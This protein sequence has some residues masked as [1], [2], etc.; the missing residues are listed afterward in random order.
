MDTA[1]TAGIV[2]VF[3]RAGLHRDLRERAEQDAAEVG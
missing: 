2:D 3:L 1:S